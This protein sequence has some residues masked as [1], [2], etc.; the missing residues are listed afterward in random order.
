MSLGFYSERNTKNYVADTHTKMWSPLKQMPTIHFIYASSLPYSHKKNSTRIIGA[1]K[2]LSS[3]FTN[4]PSSQDTDKKHVKKA[5]NIYLIILY[6]YKPLFAR[7][8]NNCANIEIYILKNKIFVKKIH[9]ILFLAK[10]LNEAHRFS[11]LILS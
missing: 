9:G 8:V 6:F 1:N 11:L 7:E 10:N 4:I 2:R 5:V 3:K